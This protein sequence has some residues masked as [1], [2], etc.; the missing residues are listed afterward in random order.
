MT[1]LERIGIL[2]LFDT[3][4]TADEEEVERGKP[5][6][7]IFLVAAQRLGVDAVHCIGFEDADLG[8][9]AL[10]SANYMYPSDVRLMHMYP[11][12][13]ERR[14]SQEENKE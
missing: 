13:V 7:D 6:P 11:R 10:E 4:V 1:G 3:I 12:N 9:Q 2:H 8:I 14:E 5:H